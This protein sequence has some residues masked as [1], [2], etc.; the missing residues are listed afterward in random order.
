MYVL[1]ITYTTTISMAYDFYKAILWGFDYKFLSGN[2]PKL[3]QSIF[4][5]M[6]F[7]MNTTVGGLMT[8]FLKFHL[9]LA[10]TNKTTIENLDKLG[11]TY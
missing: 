3:S 9:M 1:I 7:I 8:A 5:I 6:A 10:G 2:D 11:K 4:I